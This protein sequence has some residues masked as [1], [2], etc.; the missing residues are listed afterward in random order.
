MVENDEGYKMATQVFLYFF[1]GCGPIGEVWAGMGGYGWI[2]TDMGTY[3]RIWAEFNMKSVKGY[4][5]LWV[6]MHRYGWV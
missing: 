3:A 2:W 5:R 1:A 4:E 6:D